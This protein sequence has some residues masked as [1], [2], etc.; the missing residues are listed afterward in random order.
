MGVSPVQLPPTG[1]HPLSTVYSFVPIPG[2][3]Q[4]KRP[5][6]RY[7]EIER[8]YKCGWNGCEKAYGTLNHLNA[9]VTMQS[10]GAKRTP[11]EFKE[12][13]KEWK[14]KKKEEEAARKADEERHRAD[15]QQRAHEGGA[16]EAP[17]YGQMRQ[18]VGV[19]GQPPQHPQ[20]PPIGY[21]PAA[22]GNSTAPQY[23]TQSPGLPEGMAH[24]PQSP[25]GQNPQMYQQNH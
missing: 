3:Q 19:P 11:E 10:H 24:Y 6:R 8:M 2:A 5:R 4:H 1:G 12:I 13:R 7:E 22:S 9:H 18:A 20:L 14:A 16:P 23:G 17:V 15:V 21:Q 25:Y